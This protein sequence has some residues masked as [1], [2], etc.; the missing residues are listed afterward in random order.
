ML[1]GKKKPLIQGFPSA[2]TIGGH[3]DPLSPKVGVTSLTLG[4]KINEFV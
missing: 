4:V 1:G 3:C 2:I